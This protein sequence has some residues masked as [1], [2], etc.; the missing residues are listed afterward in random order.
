ME[1]NRPTLYD[2]AC[3]FCVSRIPGAT[4]PATRLS[5]ILESMFRGQQLTAMSLNYLRQQN[6]TELHQLANGQITYEAFIA[7]M[8]PVSVAREQTAKAEHQAKEAERLAQEHEWSV[9]C[10]RKGEAAEAAR[11]ARTVRETAQVAQ[12]DREREATEAV[13]IVREAEW[14]VQ[15]KHNC[16]TAEATY[17][18]RMSEPDYIAPTPYDIAR[19]YRVNHLS[20]AVTSPLSNILDALYQGRALSAAYLNYLKIKGFPRL[21]ELAIGQATYEHYIS[22]INAAKFAR[23]AAES[24]RLEQVEAQRLLREATEVARIAHESDPAYILRR[25]Y[26]ILAIDQSLLPRMMDILQSIDAGDRLTDAYFVWLNTEAQQHFT[27]ELHKT[28]HLR[29]A[30]FC[31]N[32]YRRTQDAWNAINASGHYRKCNQ[33]KSALELLGSVPAI[34]FKKPKI[35]SAMC[36]THGGVM[37]D[38]GRRNEALQ[39]GKHGHELQPRNFRP[40][41]L[42]GAVCMELGSFGEG[43]DWYAKAEERGASQQS[44]DIEL[45]GIFLRMDKAKREIMR[46]SLLAK[47]PNRYCWVNDKKNRNS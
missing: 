7:V 37:R 46:G 39:L 9:E 16:E 2:I 25:K 28:Y 32:E 44:I 3:H 18:A 27:A 43:H 5:N 11:I 29:E 45:R 23:T 24:A 13:R 20:G 36:T 34:R 8:D 38:L 15:C 22:D 42:L 1:L 35:H 47:D 14:A 17:K 33:P 6:L 30:E 12:H 41:T 10:Q 21:H 40:C 19:H 4:I 31:A 26:G